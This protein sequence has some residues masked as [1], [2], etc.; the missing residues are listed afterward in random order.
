MRKLYLLSLLLSFTS[1]AVLAQPEMP[2]NVPAALKG[3]I[4]K[5]YNALNIT[6]GDLNR[7]AYPD[8]IMILYK[9]GEKQS[10]DVIDHPEKRPLLVLL[11]K[12]D[13][14]Y[15]LAAR[16]NNAVYCI[17]CGGQMGDPFTSV[18]IKNG[19]FSVEHYG[20]SA[21]RWTRI[22]TF[23]Y[24]PAEKKWFLFKDGGDSFHAT[25]PEKV[26]TEVKTVKNFG[27]VPFEKFDIYKEQ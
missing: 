22:I 18:T 17:D 16:S 24:A 13:K 15:A 6:K 21:W 12:P 23:K 26:K 7:D 25:D 5:G 19:Y 2:V 3:F 1:L 10:S 9:D 14:T 27:K 4:P 11:G 8:A 20:G